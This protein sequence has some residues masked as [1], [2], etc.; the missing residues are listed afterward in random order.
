MDTQLENEQQAIEW[1][2]RITP[3]AVKPTKKA[4]TT[5]VSPFTSKNA[6]LVVTEEI[7]KSLFKDIIIQKKQ[8]EP[9][10]NVKRKNALWLLKRL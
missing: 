1:V 6:Y 4:K 10:A 8:Q 9:S 5:F 7:G 3:F 2:R